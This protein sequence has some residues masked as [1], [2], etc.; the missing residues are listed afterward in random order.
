M[1]KDTW[2]DA[3]R[4]YQVPSNRIA[5]R[6]LATSVVPY[7]AL[8]YLTYLS[9]S[10]SYFLTLGLSVLAAGFL[11]RVFIIFHDCGHGCFFKSPTANR[12]LSWVTAYLTFTPAYAWKH[13][14]AIHHANAGDLDHRGTGDIWTMTTSEYQAAPFWK[15]LR[16]RLYRN[17]IVLFGFGAAFVFLVFN[18]FPRKNANAREKRSV[19]AMNLALLATIVV[20]AF[21]IGLKALLLVQLP[22]ILIGGVAGIWLFY[23]QHQFEGVYWERHEDWNYV[24]V[25]MEGSSFYRLPKILQWFSGNIGFHHIHHLSP[26]IPNYYLERCHKANTIFQQVRE[27]T[28]WSSLK[29]LNFHLWDEE[30]RKL[31]SFRQWRLHGAGA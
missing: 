3:I 20:A 15:R 1:D 23:V 6:Q 16:Y 14:H 2:K 4:E 31:I 9:L 11:V 22:I 21:T 7:V 18:R 8:W 12:L 5:L 30:Q 10:V 17:P 29:S 24:R 25:A 13:E 19:L 27:I 26:R 28:L